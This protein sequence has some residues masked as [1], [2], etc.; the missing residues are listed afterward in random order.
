MTTT[1]FEKLGGADAVT[2]VAEGL[3]TRLLVDELTAPFFENVS[4][5]KLKHHQVKF[6]TIAFSGIQDDLDV[7]KYLR[8]KHMKMFTTMGLN[9]THFDKVA[10]FFVASC[11]ELNVKQELINEAVAIIGPLRVVFEE[12][13]IEFGS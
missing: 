13:A 7:P 4:M 9:E 8:D 3:Y 1:L 10:E 6:L 2:A 5:A 11:V 12:A